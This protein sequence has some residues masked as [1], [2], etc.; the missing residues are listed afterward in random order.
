MH[1]IIIIHYLLPLNLFLVSCK[2]FSLITCAYI[3]YLFVTLT[4]TLPSFFI[5]R[6][7]ERKKIKHDPSLVFY[8]Q[9]TQ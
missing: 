7:I 4:K 5:V 8:L 3:S 2:I 9:F 6:T 1:I